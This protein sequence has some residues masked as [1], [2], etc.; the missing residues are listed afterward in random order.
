MIS[1]FDDEFCQN[2]ENYYL[3]EKNSEYLLL[4]E[5]N[6]ISHQI[7]DE[8]NELNELIPEE[9]PIFNNNIGYFTFLENPSSLNYIS[10]ASTGNTEPNSEDKQTDLLNQKRK[11]EE[12]KNKDKNEVFSI[13]EDKEEEDMEENIGENKIGLEEEDELER[14]KKQKNKNKGRR[15]K[16]VNYNNK[17]E[18]TKFKEDNI[19]RKIKTSI[20]KYILEI[21]NNSLN[22]TFLNFYALDTEVSENLRKDINEELF[23]RT[24]CD[25]YMNS[26]LNKRYIQKSRSNKKLI[27][28]ILKENTEKRTIYILNKTFQDILN[29]IRDKDR[30]YFLG[31]I[32]KKEEKNKNTCIK[33]YMQLVEELLNNYENWFYKKKARNFTKIII[34]NK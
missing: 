24:I 22:N 18:H 2:C 19:V 7:L 13:K 21:L 11:R 33:D 1:F 3:G 32:R 8:P 5:N 10:N 29:Y 16:D 20:F 30:E 6:E 28:K 23:K 34:K 9:R 14:N 12:I 26:D 31:I 17:A 27:Q 25:I 4:G 15:K